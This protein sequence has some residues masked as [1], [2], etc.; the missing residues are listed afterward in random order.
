VADVGPVYTLEMPT[1][2]WIDLADHPRQRNIER[3]ARKPHWRLAQRAS[4]AVKEA[5]RLV[6]AA[7]L[8]EL[9]HKVD[10]HTR[11]L[12]WRLGK[13]PAPDTVFVTVHRVRSRDEL[14]ALYDIFHV[15]AAGESAY[16]QVYGAFRQTGLALKS[17][18]LKEGFL[19]SALNIALRGVGKPQQDKRHSEPIDIYAAVEAFKVEL[20]LLDSVD[21]QPEVFYS[22]VVAA[23]LIGLALYPETLEFFA[24]L[25]GRQGEKRAGRADPVEA[26]LSLIAELKNQRNSWVNAQQAELCART[27]RALEAWRE[28][29]ASEH[30]WLQRKPRPMDLKPYVDRLKQL[31][32]I[33]GNPRL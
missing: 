30:N 4:G 19:A 7:E 22:G 9:L 15:P 20:E 26:V 27:L 18:R 32:G 16:D 23:A 5:L 12:L 2:A 14:D 21:P 13:L 3:Q 1:G 33:E 17:R 24:R 25:S 6:V 28:G 29:A 10:G 8:D 31:K 11:A